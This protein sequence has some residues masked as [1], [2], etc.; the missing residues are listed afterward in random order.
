[1]PG[2]WQDFLLPRVGH[3]E[4]IR[5]KEGLE[6]NEGSL[7]PPRCHCRHGH[8]RVPSVSKRGLEFGFVRHV[9]DGGDGGATTGGD[10]RGDGGDVGNSEYSGIQ[11]R[12][13]R[14]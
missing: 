2:P 4:K 13:K 11:R 6:R 12:V 7:L 9:G 5:W 3:K 14:Q 10:W 1:M 8:A